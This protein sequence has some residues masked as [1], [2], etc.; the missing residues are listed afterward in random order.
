MN[1]FFSK[2]SE[3]VNCN[4]IGS[5]FEELGYKHNP[6]EWSHFIDSSKI[7]LK[8]VLL[9]NGNIYSSVPVAYMNVTYANMKHLFVSIEYE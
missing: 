3:L 9:H 4:D 7:S 5:L 8:R 6:D 1:T 2:I